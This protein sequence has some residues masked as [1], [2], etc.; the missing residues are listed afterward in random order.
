MPNPLEYFNAGVI[1]YNLKKINELNLSRSFFEAVNEIEKPLLQDQDILN[2]VFSRNGGVKLIS[3][4]Y[5]MTKI[6]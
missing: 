2:S 6:L 5:N 4:K 3:N 1:L